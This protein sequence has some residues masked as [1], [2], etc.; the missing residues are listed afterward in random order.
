MLKCYLAMR[1]HS[2]TEPISLPTEQIQSREPLSLLPVLCHVG[3]TAPG[4]ARYKLGAGIWLMVG[5][6]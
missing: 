1:T 3:W 5:V 6:N 4:K 2:V